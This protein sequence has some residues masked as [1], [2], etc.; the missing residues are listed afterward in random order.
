[1]I[2]FLNLKENVMAGIVRVNPDDFDRRITRL[3]E[4]HNSLEE[5]LNQLN[6]TIALLNHTVESMSRREDKRQQ[7]LDRTMLFGVGGIV[8]AIVAWVVRGGLGQ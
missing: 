7:F 1:M 2:E 8:S 5:S 3:E 6:T 4:S